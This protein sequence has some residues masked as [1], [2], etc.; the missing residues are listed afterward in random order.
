MSRGSVAAILR[1]ARRNVGRSRWR[2]VLVGVLIGLPVAG[3]VGGATW[4][5][6]TTP[7]AEALVTSIMGAADL[8]VYPGPREQ[9]LTTED[10][11]AELPLGSLIEPMAKIDGLLVLPGRRVRVQ[12]D[13]INLEGLG[14]GMLTLI[15]GRLPTDV[16]EV[17]ISNSVAATAQLV[18][19]SD[20]QL[21]GFEKSTV[22][23]LIENPFRLSSREVLLDRRLADAPPLAAERIWLVAL[24]AGADTPDL[25]TRLSVNPRSAYFV[26]GDLTPGMLVLGG[27]AL[28]ESVLVAAAAFA[29]GIRRR[30]REL[31]LLAAAGAS[32][33][34]LAGTVLAES[35]IV[36]GVAAAIGVLTGIGLLALASPWF[37]HLT[38][39][40][41]PSLVID[42]VAIGLAY[43]IGLVAGISAAVVPAWTAARLPPLVALSGRR[44]P[45]GSAR[46]TL[47]LGVALVGISVAL[48]AFGA[49]MLLQDPTDGTAPLLLGGGAILGV[50]GF[51][52]C[53]PWLVERLEWL[54]SHLPLAGRIALRETA[55]ARSRTA[56]IVTASLAALAAALAIS[57]AVAST[58]GAFTSVPPMRVDQLIV[59][60]RDATR[61]GP[62]IA[63]QLSAVASAEVR[64]IGFASSD[65]SE[66]RSLNAF[67][68]EAGEAPTLDPAVPCVECRQTGNLSM[69][70]PDLLSALS[71]PPDA[72]VV[73]SDAILLL[74]N[75]PFDARAATL[76]VSEYDERELAPGDTTYVMRYT[77]LETLP[78][79]AVDVG[80][81]ANGLFPTMFIAP[82]TAARLGF[83]PYEEEDNQF[84]IR[85]GRPVT[86]ADVAFAASTLADSPGTFAEAALR[87][88]D[89]TALVRLIATVL[90]VILALTITAIAVALGESEARA[91]QRTLLAVGA[92]PSLRR[93]IV[94]AR[95]AVIAVLAA[96]LAVPAGL[97]PVWGILASRD[98]PVVI[99]LPEVLVVGI[100]LPVVAMAGA[101]L[102]SRPIP[103]WS[104]LR[105]VASG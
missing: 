82:E 18:I 72:M 99:P 17:A 94:A 89:P 57:S 96:L 102:L 28:I 15:E 90:S 26:G 81:A 37:D 16:Q 64:Q 27:L 51:G 46:R 12:V 19:G 76:A 4:F 101:V 68:T 32:R 41:N 66:G 1:V 13:S 65:G 14:R 74:V 63:A 9:A 24:P 61:L 59:I 34:Q 98:M 25:G 7:S 3:M 48:T 22:V 80:A 58:R 93:R 67:I 49:A 60:G 33:R 30:Q 5:R 44:P 55:R 83:R 62:Q 23:G 105:D 52:A 56:P 53:S 47:I 21:D 38:D 35:L 6:T 92:D 87:P 20:I 84:L 71:V 100:V 88:L 43:L 79:R 104:A 75:E 11:R 78:A 97:L 103:S 10:L 77:H 39:R 8:S 54:G 42:P 70:T 69:G 36:T 29:V 2:S 85:L 40:R 50:L 95:A 31:G 91:D 73:P 45:T 86:E